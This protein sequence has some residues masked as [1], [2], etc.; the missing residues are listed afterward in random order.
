MSASLATPSPEA[1][2]SHRERPDGPLLVPKHRYT[3]A[4]FAALEDEKLW[5]RTWQLACVEEQV[6]EAG[7]YLEVQVGRDSVLVVRGSDGVLRAFHNVCSHRGFQLCEGS[8]NAE[9]LRCGFHDW[10]YD[11]KG[12]LRGMPYAA[13]FGAV[14]RDSLGLRPVRVENWGRMVFVNLDPSAESLERTLSPVPREL[15]VFRLEEYSCHTAGS[16]PM[17]GNWKTTIDAFS[18]IYHLLGIHPQMKAMMDDLNTRFDNWSGGHSMMCIP[19]GKNSPILG[20]LTEREIFSSYVYTYGGMLDHDPSEAGSVDVP[21]GMSA[22]QHAEKRVKERGRRL[23]LDYSGLETSRL[24]DDWHYLVFPNLIFNVHA[25]MYTIF[26]A[27]PGRD[28]NQSSF[29]FFFFRRLPKDGSET[30]TKPGFTRFE[31]HTGIEVLDQDLDGIARVQRGLQ[32]SGFED[33][34]FGNFET[35]LANMHQELD[36]RLEL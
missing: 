20:K 10:C 13:R 34:I 16:V 14:E 32:S 31:G 29:D 28:P 36:R 18:E 8:G 23:G 17:A 5:P 11:L 21:E 7:D 4:A 27:T 12:R 22:R 15:G 26:R 30:H 2:R 1:Y 3:D 33:M 19:F 35:R 6:P 25:E 9:E 24:L